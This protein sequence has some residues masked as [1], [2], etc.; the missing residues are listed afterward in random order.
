MIIRRGCEWRSFIHKHKDYFIMDFNDCIMINNKDCSTTEVQRPTNI[1]VHPSICPSV[2]PFVCLS[3]SVCRS[4]YR[5]SGWPVA[6]GANF[7]ATFV[8]VLNS[9]RPASIFQSARITGTPCECRGHCVRL[10]HD[11]QDGRGHLGNHVIIMAPLTG[12]TRFRL[13]SKS[14]RRRHTMRILTRVPF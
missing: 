9:R 11:R 3:V 1:S 8:A 14:R 5:R 10:S 6:H 12:R 4:S 2:R 13:P 7:C